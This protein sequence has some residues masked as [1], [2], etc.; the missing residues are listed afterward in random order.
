MRQPRAELWLNVN[1]AAGAA[2]FR[3]GWPRAWNPHPA[4]TEARAAWTRGWW[5]ASDAAAP[6]RRIGDPTT[7]ADVRRAH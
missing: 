1:R 5:S 6:D 7:M 2:S 3:A 4:A